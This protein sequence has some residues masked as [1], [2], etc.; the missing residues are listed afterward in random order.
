MDKAKF[1]N[2]KK[3]N[4]SDINSEVVIRGAKAKL[5]RL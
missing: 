4:K 2:T 3:I 1:F 5:K